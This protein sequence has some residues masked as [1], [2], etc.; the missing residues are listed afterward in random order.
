MDFNEVLRND[1][2]GPTQHVELA[3]QTGPGFQAIGKH[4]ENGAMRNLDFFDPDPPLR[5]I[6]VA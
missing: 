1:D 5:N 2:G 4:D 6:G 3:L